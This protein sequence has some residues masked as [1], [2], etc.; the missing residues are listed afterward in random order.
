[1]AP[2]GLRA[3][4]PGVRAVPAASKDAHPGI[5]AAPPGT[6]VPF[7]RIAAKPCPRC[8]GFSTREPAAETDTEHVSRRCGTAGLVFRSPH[9][10]GLSSQTQLPCQTRKGAARCH[11]RHRERG[12]HKTRRHPFTI[13]PRKQCFKMKK[14]FQVETLWARV[15]ATPEA[16]APVTVRPNVRGGLRHRAHHCHGAR[17]SRQIPAKRATAGPPRDP[18]GPL[19]PAGRRPSC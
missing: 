15:G 1:V 13:P 17:G 19:W 6:P 18:P 9:L 12:L 7:L 16:R 3:Q 10:D 5:P 14:M 8:C 4:G 2:D 11:K